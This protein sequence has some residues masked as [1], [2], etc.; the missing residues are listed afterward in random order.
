MLPRKADVIIIGAGVIGASIAYY[1][2]KENIQA[3]V[4][5]KKEIAT[6][7][8]GAC[9]GLLLLQ[10][11]KPGIHMDMALAS[12]RRFPALVQELDHP[13]EYENKGGLV[14]IE[15]EEELA[16]MQLF[17][18]KRKKHSVDISLL[19]TEQAREKEPAL[20]KNIIGATFS[21]LDSQANPILLT[22]GF[23]RAAQKA[24][25]T[26]FS[27]TPV[28]EIELT[29]GRVAAVHTDK[30]RIETRII[31][32][33]AGTFAADIGAMVNLTIPIKPRRGQVLVTEAT[34]PIL[35]R[36]ILSA[37][38][39]AVKFNPEI[40][41]AGGVGFAVEQ[42][43]NGN[44]LIGSTR[45]FV[46]FDKHTTYEGVQ[47]IANT[48]LRVIPGLENLHVIRA[49]AGLRPYTP[50]GLPILGKVESVDGFIMAAGHEGDGIT[51]APITGEMIAR[52]VAAEAAPFPFNDFRLERFTT[53]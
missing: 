15:T 5:D 12:I 39:I 11:K 27:N 53:A 34:S 26:V 22:L 4:L 24:G 43:A 40:A 38:Y 21:P 8:S 13:I 31:I 2:S 52:L 9:E 46:G 18:E 7:S 36:C 47:N 19:S 1:L 49:F 51:L 33:A 25:A 23:L 10:S 14:V 44:I 41:E 28:R 37:M 6:G 3:V 30:G 17:V 42:T 50:D 16:A 20:S 45:E 48:I 29:Q 32:N 35:K